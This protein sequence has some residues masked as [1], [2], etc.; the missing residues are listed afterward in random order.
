MP[1]VS[2]TVRQR[3]LA[4]RLRELRTASGLTTA[5]VTARLL[6]S[7]TKLSRLETGQRRVSQRDVRDLCQLYQVG[8]QETAHLMDLARQAQE[9]GWWTQFTDLGLV[10]FIG[11]EQ[12][13][14][15][16]TS[17]AMYYMPPLMQTEDYARAIIR[18][19]E[20]KISPEILEER[21]MARLKRQE[22][23]D[24]DPPPRYRAILDEAVLHREV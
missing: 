7:A 20:R 18:G 1:D 6:F 3:E 16:I 8:Q 21:V 19:I 11:L 24:R 14:A 15:A 17:Y 10:P 4:N 5:E 22:I 23:L 13:A 9:R 12:E 2:P